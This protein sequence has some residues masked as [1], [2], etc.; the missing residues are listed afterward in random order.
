VQ[1]IVFTPTQGKAEGHREGQIEPEALKGYTDLRAAQ[2]MIPH[3]EVN[4]Y[5]HGGINQGIGIKGQLEEDWHSHI[6][7]SEEGQEHENGIDPVVYVYG[8]QDNEDQIDP[9]NYHGRLHI[10][11]ENQQLRQDYQAHGDQ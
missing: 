5:E 10:P 11:E 7:Q 9:M 4:R 3:Q 1:D 8:R 6:Q 2:K